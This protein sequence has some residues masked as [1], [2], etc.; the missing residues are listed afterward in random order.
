MSVQA[1]YTKIKQDIAQ[2][3]ARSG[4]DPNGIKVIAVTKY[5][6]T[7]RAREALAAGITDLGENRDDGFKEKHREIS[8]EAVWHFIGTLQ[9]RKVKN[10]I[11]DVDFIHSLDRFSLAKE[12]E[13][14]A[15]RTV[16]CFIQVNASGEESKHGLPPENV[17]SF[18][19]KLEAYPKIKVVGLMTMAPHTDDEEVIRQTFRKV[20][21]L[22]EEIKEKRYAH[23]PCGELSM[24]MSND[25]TIAV[26]EG[27]TYVRI[28]SAL[29]GE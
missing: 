8:G 25:Y 29:V 23:A 20:K 22:Q 3:A 21:R 27:S 11:M 18:V 16:N 4:R 7:E 14:R 12:I 19:D 28:G 1:K 13:K 9:S 26:E 5:V 15:D 17:I 2:A 24:G 6:T 10:I